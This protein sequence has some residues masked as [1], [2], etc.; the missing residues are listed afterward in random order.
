MIVCLTGVVVVAAVFVLGY[1]W[2]SLDGH[3]VGR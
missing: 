2:S 3:G 1:A